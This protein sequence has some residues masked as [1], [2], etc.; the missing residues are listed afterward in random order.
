MLET[1]AAH[2]SRHRVIWAAAK[3]AAEALVFSES[4]GMARARRRGSISFGH[5]WSYVVLGE[6]RRGLER[7]RQSRREIKSHLEWERDEG[8]GGGGAA[9]VLSPELGRCSHDL[10]RV[11]YEG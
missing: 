2:T 3:P 9:E 5:A 8:R 11:W 10:Q 1:T 4:V 6:R 7:M